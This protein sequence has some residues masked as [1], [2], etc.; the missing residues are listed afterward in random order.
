MYQ[1]C[2]AGNELLIV[3]DILAGARRSRNFPRMYH[4]RLGCDSNRLVP[5][6]WL[7]MAIGYLLEVITVGRRHCRKTTTSSIARWSGSQLGRRK[8]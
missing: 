4:S 7:E 3:T 8:L 2:H 5:G 6:A 1:A